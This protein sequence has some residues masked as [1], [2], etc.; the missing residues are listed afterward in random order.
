MNEET[1]SFEQFPV[2]GVKPVNVCDNRFVIVVY[3]KIHSFHVH[4]CDFPDRNLP[5]NAEMHALIELTETMNFRIQISHRN[6]R[7][8][9]FEIRKMG[10]L[11]FL[12]FFLL[13]YSSCQKN[14]EPV[15]PRPLEDVISL[16]YAGNQYDSLLSLL[17]GLPPGDPQSN[18]QRLKQIFRA[19]AMAETGK[20]DSAMILLETMPDVIH[21]QRANEYLQSMRALTLF[22]LDSF[23]RSYEVLGSMREWLFTDIRTKALNERIEGR[24][25]HHFE[26]YEESIL[27]LKSS[28]KHFQEAGLTKSVAENDLLLA[29]IYTD[30]GSYDEAQLK[31]GEAENAFRQTGDSRGLFY[32]YIVAFNYYRVRENADSA[33]YF[34]MKAME[35]ADYTTDLQM[36]TAL[37]YSLGSVENML[38]NKK[39]ALEMLERI[40]SLDENYYESATVR[41]STCI[42]LAELYNEMQQ[43]EKARD[44]AREAI[45]LID[46]SSFSNSRYKAYRALSVATMQS[47]PSLAARYLDSAVINLEQYNAHATANMSLFI[48]TAEKFEDASH[49]IAR[50]REE[51]Q[52]ESLIFYVIVGGGLLLALFYLLYLQ[53]RKRNRQTSHQLVKKNLDQINQDNQANELFR[54]Q[55]A[56]LKEDNR[57]HHFSQMQKEAILFH[58]FEEWLKEN[59]RFL[60]PGL[61]LDTASRELAT[62][63][64]YLSG[65]I[66]AQGVK[67]TQIIN[68]YRIREAIRIYSDE[69]DP[70][71]LSTVEETATAVGFHSKSVFFEAFRRE[72]GM[73]PSQFRQSI[74]NKGR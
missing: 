1:G 45:H 39:G 16:F 37:W 68:R 19:G 7:G 38:G 10:L 62:N 21:E 11:S 53:M 22:R 35:T 30:I 49:Q 48:R 56:L 36:T 66:N 4:L 27:L 54:E 73:S 3:L 47:D 31:I 25:Q 33:R 69:N 74:R 44:Y 15:Y 17:D 5:E 14:R 26:Q 60:D 23:Q 72:T 61:N 43:H 24:I 65:A 41:I 18:P 40:I 8:T 2:G 46:R 42:R 12:L 52:R 63:R 51:K 50:M 32:L 55:I 58:D 57:E 67:F 70:L 71:H 13:L 34:V 28:R 20:A 6:V 59:K 9:A 64:S 29:S